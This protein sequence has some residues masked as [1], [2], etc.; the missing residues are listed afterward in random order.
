M[1]FDS[2]NPGG[3]GPSRPSIPVPIPPFSAPLTSQ[4]KPLTRTFQNFGK[5]LN[6]S[7]KFPL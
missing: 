4:I 7:L 3:P 6:K 1:P 5:F 2:E